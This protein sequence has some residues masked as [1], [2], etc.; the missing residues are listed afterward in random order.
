MSIDVGIENLGEDAGERQGVFTIELFDESAEQL[1]QA[2]INLPLSSHLG[3]CFDYVKEAKTGEM[4]LLSKISSMIP[5]SRVV[6]GYSPL[7]AKKPL[8]NEDFGILVYKRN[9]ESKSFLDKTIYVW[10]TKLT[11]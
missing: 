6:I 9:E 3:V 2:S 5:F 4:F 10:P 11:A 1:S 8:R 7:F